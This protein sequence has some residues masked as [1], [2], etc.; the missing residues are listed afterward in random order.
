MFDLCVCCGTAVPE[1]RQVCPNCESRKG[2]MPPAKPFEIGRRVHFPEN[3]K[4]QINGDTY[5]ST[6]EVMIRM[7]DRYEDALVQAIINEAK[8]SGVTEVTVLN[9][10]AILEAIKKQIPQKPI[11][12]KRTGEVFHRAKCPRCRREFPDLGGVQEYLDECE[13]PWYCGECGQ[14]IDWEV[15]N[16]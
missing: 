1:G 11:E 12:I 15:Q 3:V 6:R 14:A 4:I 10:S 7:A 8:L 2:N 13:Q 16:G 9:K 5:S